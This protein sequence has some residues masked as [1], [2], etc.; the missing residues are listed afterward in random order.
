MADGERRV[1]PLDP[2]DA[3]PDVTGVAPCG[4]HLLDRTQARAQDLDQVERVVLDLGHGADRGDRVE[5][6]FDRRGLERDDGDRGVDRPDDLVD[7]AVA[8]R[9]DAAQLLGQD[10][11]RFERLE[12]LVIER[13]ER[14]AAVHR[15]GHQRVDL[16]ARAVM[17]ILGVVGHDR[18]ADHFRRP[19]ALMGYADELIA[20]PEGADNLGRGWEQ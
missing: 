20:E 11:V 2:D 5:D 3:R 10:Q 13:I 18:L 14:R 15:G 19:V 8:D 17:E 4:H 7:L 16:A 9:A 12:L 6:P 1:Q